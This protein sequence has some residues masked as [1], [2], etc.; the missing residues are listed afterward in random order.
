MKG[1][2]RIGRKKRRHVYISVELE[3]TALEL[4]PEYADFSRWAERQLW[5]S[6]VAEHGEETVLATLYD[7]QNNLEP[8]EKLPESE[9]YTDELPV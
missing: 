5:Q 3:R 2:Q 7:V 9:R 8:S 6:L 1:I 4:M